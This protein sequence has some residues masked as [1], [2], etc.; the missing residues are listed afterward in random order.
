MIAVTFGPSFI[1]S[2][3]LPDVI[4]QV[5]LNKWTKRFKNKSYQSLKIG[6]EH[7]LHTA[8]NQKVIQL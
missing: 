4:I 1:L 5:P 8:Q 6:M 2:Q 7:M 3:A